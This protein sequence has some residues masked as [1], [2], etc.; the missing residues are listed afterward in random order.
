VFDGLT[1][2]SSEIFGNFGEGTE[3][4][5]VCGDSV[6]WDFV[7][8]FCFFSCREVRAAFLWADLETLAAG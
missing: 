6:R 3:E 2:G 8:F 7:E 5:S 4:S 1:G